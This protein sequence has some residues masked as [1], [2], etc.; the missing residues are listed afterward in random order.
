MW[1]KTHVTDPA[2]I[3]AYINQRQIIEEQTTAY[4]I[5]FKITGFP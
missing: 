3:N 1:T 4:I 5:F 2:V